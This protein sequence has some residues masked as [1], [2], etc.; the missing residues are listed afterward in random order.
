MRVGIIALQHESNT[1]I[2]APTTLADFRRETLLTGQAI[3][4]HFEHAHQEIGGFIEGLRAAGATIVPIFSAWA[5]PGGVISAETYEEMLAMI[6]RGLAEA[7]PLD[8]LLVAPHGA[9]VSAPHRDM[10]GHW[11][12]VVREKV[13]PKLPIVCTLDCHANV[14]PR[15]I[16]ACN[17]TVAY[18]SNPHLDQRQ[19]GLEAAKLLVR[20]I[21][22]EIRSTQA[23]AFPRVA[24]NIERQETAQLPCRPMYEFADAMLKRPGVL[25]N[26]IVLGFPYS[27]V[28]EMGSSFIVVTDDDP[29]LAQQLADELAE[30]LWQ[31]RQDF[32]AQLIG[33][34]DAV[35]Q[36][37]ADAGPVCLLDM[38]DNIGGGSPADGTLIAHALLRRGAK[39][40]RS[41]VAI[42]D[43]ES[44]AAAR[45]A[46]IGQRVHLRIGGKTDDMHD[47]PLDV[48]VRVRSL[49][50][51][52]FTED[53]PRH[54]GR[55]EYH[56]G[57]TA[58]VEADANLIIQITSLRAM[59]V[60]LN[61]L[62][63]CG[64]DPA[65]FHMLVAK[66]VVAPVAA[67]AEVCR[68]F[69]RVNTPGVTT[70]DMLSLKYHHRRRPLFPFENPPN[71]K[72]SLDP[73]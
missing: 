52:H 61:Q 60:S 20:T 4:P 2:Q 1:N 47:P 39:A 41:F 36:A 53:K 48:N 12:S 62:R 71:W 21:R 22:G 9:G 68:R 13:G 44:V 50:D 72:L 59:P 70:A 31:H 16:A 26:S 37:S 57:D 18:R 54:G 46:G 25:S 42:C 45:R 14:S 27:D 55:V 11:L 64:L 32:V 30:Y 56:M 19:R 23:A 40:P 5:L 51:G 63:T 67:Y 58:I 35:D 28:E 10:D 24:I 3:I 49:H 66:G 65:S 7:G 17:A 38:G 6:L 73:K 33:I 43:A 15:M 69:I 34:E 8:G 29:S